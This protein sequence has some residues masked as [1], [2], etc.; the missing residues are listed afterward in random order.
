[1]S[2]EEKQEVI[3]ELKATRKRLFEGDINA[4]IRAGERLDKLIKFL[5]G[6]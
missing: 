3:K 1:M 6:K 4:C 5:E 2:K